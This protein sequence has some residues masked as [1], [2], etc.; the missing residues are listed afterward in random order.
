M[1]YEASENYDLNVSKGGFLTS[2]TGPKNT[3]IKI[4]LGLSLGL[5]F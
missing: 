3:G 5:S 4:N 1:K 2:L